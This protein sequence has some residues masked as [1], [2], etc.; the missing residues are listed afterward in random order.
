MNGNS[1][2]APATEVKMNVRFLCVRDAVFRRHH[3]VRK[4]V[5]LIDY[6]N[7]DYSGRFDNKK[8]HKKSIEPHAR[9]EPPARIEPHP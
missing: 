3:R 9:I 1:N 8:F 4:V 2:T 7:I 6:S 5:Q